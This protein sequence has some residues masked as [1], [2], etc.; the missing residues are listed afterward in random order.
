MR[1]SERKTAVLRDKPPHHEKKKWVSGGQ[2]NKV[3][4]HKTAS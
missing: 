1:M 2:K 3:S 4:P